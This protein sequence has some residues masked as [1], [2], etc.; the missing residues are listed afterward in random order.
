MADEV[1]AKKR[2]RSTAD[3]VNEF[4][5]IF[6]SIIIKKMSIS[7]KRKNEDK[8]NSEEETSAPAVKR[9]RG[10]PKG[11]TKKTDKASKK[12]EA[13]GKSKKSK[14]KEEKSSEEDSANN[15]EDS[16]E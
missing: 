1:D 13:K 2:G 16:D 8:A 12:S 3:K 6:P 4:S 15:Q 9:G 14:K 7:Q 5:Q 11:A 10:R